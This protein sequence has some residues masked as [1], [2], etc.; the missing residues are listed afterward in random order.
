MRKYKLFALSLLILLLIP[1]FASA[2][3]LGVNRVTMT[4]NN[5]LRGGYA[6]EGLTVSS[7]TERNVS[8]Y[9]EARGEIAD[10]ISFSPADQ[11]KIVNSNSPGNIAIIVQPPSDAR[12]DEY[13]AIVVIST[14]PLGEITGNIGANVEVAFEVRIKVIVTDTQILACST[15]GAEILDA[16]IGRDL[17][18][19]ISVRNHGNVRIDP[20]FKLEI[21]DQEIENLL[22][23]ISYKPEDEIFPTVSER[24][25]AQLENDLEEGQYWVYVTTPLCGTNRQ[26]LTFSILEKGGISDIGEFIR[27]EAEPWALTGE[28]VP[29]NVFF[30]NRGERFVSAQF[31]GVVSKDGRIMEVLTS[32]VRDVAPDELAVFELFYTASEFGQYKINGRVHYNNKITYERGSIINVNPS[33]QAPERDNSFLS[34]IL[35]I[36]LIV[37]GILIFLIMRKKKKFRY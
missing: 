20:E 13:E 29:I 25:E 5:V 36:V 28:T 3:L 35:L 6:Q 15:G 24:I 30:R 22:S 12:V 21:Y 10:W 11:P 33:G 31:K 1:S 7:G 14:G 23:V 18:F 26:L 27:I 34:T 16:E 8:V 9:Y 17:P 2:A 19:I 4:Y 32:E 37:I